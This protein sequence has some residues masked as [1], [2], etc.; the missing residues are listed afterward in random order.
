M[1]VTDMFLLRYQKYVAVFS[2]PWPMLI[3]KHGHERHERQAPTA[4]G[5]ITKCDMPSSCVIIRTLGHKG[6]YGIHGT[7]IKEVLSQ[8]VGG[9]GGTMPMAAPGLP[10]EPW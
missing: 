8:G 1:A 3:V 4:W 9:G 10:W 6:R 2:E 5:S 7:T